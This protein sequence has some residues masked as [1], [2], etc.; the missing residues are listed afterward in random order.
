MGDSSK[1]AALIYLSTDQRQQEIADALGDL[2]SGELRRKT[3][4]TGRIDASRSGT[5][6]ARR[7]KEAS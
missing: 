3:S 6:C 7:R 4:R 5:Q 2:A 1:R